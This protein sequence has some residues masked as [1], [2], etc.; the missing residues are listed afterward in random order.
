MERNWFSG[1]SDNSTIKQNDVKPISE[2]EGQHVKRIRRN[3]AV[4]DT[5]TMNVNDAS[6]KQLTEMKHL[7]TDRFEH[8]RKEFNS[9]LHWRHKNHLSEILQDFISVMQPM[10][11]TLSLRETDQCAQQMNIFIAVSSSNKTL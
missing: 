8:F 4:V 9:M 10:A 7:L 6:E 5:F 11:A 2:S 1:L 3:K